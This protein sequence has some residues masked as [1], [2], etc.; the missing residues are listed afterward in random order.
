MIRAQNRRNM[1]I[2][3]AIITL[4]L[5]GIGYAFLTGDLGI[6]GSARIREKSWDVR[7]QNIKVVPGS[8]SANTPVITD[9]TKIT[10]TVDL[11]TTGDYYEFYVDIANNGTIDAMI[12]SISI[13][14]LSEEQK[15]YLDYSVTYSSGLD[16]A[17][18]QELKAGKKE[19]IK[20]RS[21]YKK[22]IT[23]ND[24]PTENKSITFKVEINYVQRDNTA[25]TLTHP[26]CTRATT[27]HKET[28]NP[29]SN[30]NY[31]I[32]AGYNSG[33]TIT[34]G[35]LGTTGTFSSGDAFDCDVN[36][37]KEYDPEKERFYY[38]SDLN[39]NS[40]FGV[41]IYYNNVK[42]GEPYTN[43][44]IAYDSDNDP[45]ANGPKTL[46]SH[47]PTRSQWGK[48]ILSNTT[49][50]IKDENG[51]VYSTFSYSGY[52]ARLITYQELVSACGSN[53]VG[54]NGYFDNCQYFM[55]NT[56]FANNIDLYGYWIENVQSSENKPISID[57][58]FR[59]F[60]Y[61]Y[62]ANSSRYA[63]RPV[64]ELQ[65]SKMNY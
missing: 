3:I 21:F 49:R 45:K 29:A 27:L 7:F 6:L 62:N 8:V 44:G 50:K 48:A 65:K 54:N 38:V 46:L 36:G 26:V 64:I 4:I 17:S 31:C 24:L 28:C 53:N 2:L 30:N 51:T 61:Y 12:D 1:Y 13:T 63:T 5:I 37:D 40:N 32:V 33:D 47:L 23:A 9:N 39:T 35:S 41:L 42:S 25:T 20:V 52:S 58:G 55:E 59:S 57:T 22:D 34:Y 16:L 19:Q 10:Y 18:K 11:N 56:S 14:G 60:M 15:K 43:Y